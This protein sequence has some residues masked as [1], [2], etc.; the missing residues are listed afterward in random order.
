MGVVSQESQISNLKFEI[1]GAVPSISDLK[2]G[3]E[4]SNGYPP[5]WARASAASGVLR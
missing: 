3:F 1:S 5:T 4:I 2:L